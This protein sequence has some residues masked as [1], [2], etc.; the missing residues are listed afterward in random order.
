MIDPVPRP[1]VFHDFTRRVLRERRSDPG[2]S[3]KQDLL[4]LFL[5]YKVP[6]RVLSG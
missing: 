2:L 4:S 3:H 1:Q 5:N 6:E